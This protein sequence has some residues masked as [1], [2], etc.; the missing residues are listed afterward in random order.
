MKKVLIISAVFLF[1]DQLIK[2]LMTHFLNVGDTVEVIKN[3]FSIT[4]IQNTGAA[5]SIM[6]QNTVFLILMTFVVLIAIYFIVIK[7]HELN[8]FESITYGILVGGILGNFVDR[9]INGY[10]IDYMHFTFGSYSFPIF[11]F[12][13]TCIVTSVILI[14]IDMYRRRNE[15]RS[16]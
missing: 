15:I 8:K 14:I 12:A 13:D 2:G 7:D 6:S 1:V 16:K 4:L 11:N 5:F 3:F 9:I 10:V